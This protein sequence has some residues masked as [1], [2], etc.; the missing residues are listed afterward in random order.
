M[1]AQPACTSSILAAYYIG[2]FSCIV[3]N[4]LH[5]HWGWFSDETV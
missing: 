1:D 4:D 5:N 2:I 3:F